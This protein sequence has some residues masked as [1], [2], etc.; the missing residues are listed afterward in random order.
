M[1]FLFKTLALG[2]IVVLITTLYPFIYTQDSSNPV[3][4]CRSLDAKVMLY[5][6]RIFTSLRNPRHRNEFEKNYHKIVRN[7]P[8]PFF[9]NGSSSYLLKEF[10]KV[11]PFLSCAFIYW[12]DEFEPEL[13]LDDTSVIRK[14]AAASESEVWSKGLDSLFK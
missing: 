6:D 10:P 4:P 5:A 3:N 2:V 14:M 7:L 12:L 13:I 1:G 8:L 9:F 11:P